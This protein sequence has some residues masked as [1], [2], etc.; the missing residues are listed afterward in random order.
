MALAEPAGSGISL[1]AVAVEAS[2]AFTNPL[3]QEPI[4][5]QTIDEATAQVM[6][7]L[8]VE[9]A[10]EAK[11]AAASRLLIEQ[12]LVA[13]VSLLL[14]LHASQGSRRIPVAIDTH[15]SNLHPHAIYRLRELFVRKR[16]PWRV[17]PKA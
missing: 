12:L 2:Q 4:S 16:S 14:D 17:I 11:A 3:H 13:R 5:S 1:P 9:L 10:A 15:R 6:A 8:Q 7:A